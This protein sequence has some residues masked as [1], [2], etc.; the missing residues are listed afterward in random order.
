MRR[1]PLLA[2]AFA[3]VL[4]LA[5]CGQDG[6]SK[7][8]EPLGDDAATSATPSAGASPTPSAGATPFDDRGN[9]ALR[10]K[11]EARGP[12]QDAVVDAWISYWAS[13]AK[14][15][16]GTAVL[17]ISPDPAPSKP[18]KPRAQKE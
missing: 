12:D 4:A 6:P 9:D 3:L 8:V 1:M 18:R 5:G 14:S 15:Y 2:L 16:G 11:I 10:G 17:Q 13:R 7:K